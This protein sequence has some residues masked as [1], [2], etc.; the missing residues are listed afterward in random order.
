MIAGRSIALLA[1]YALAPEVRAEIEGA[2]VLVID[3]GQRNPALMVRH[4]RHALIHPMPQPRESSLIGAR[5]KSPGFDEEV[6]A[7]EGRR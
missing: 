3:I 7:G 6:P 4:L 1:G 2:G 5:R